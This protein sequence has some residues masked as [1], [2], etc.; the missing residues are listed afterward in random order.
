[1]TAH[2]YNTEHVHPY[3]WDQVAEAIF[4]RYPN[5]FARHVLSEDTVHRELLTG[6]TLYTRRFI[7]KTNKVPSWG[8]KYLSRLAR[9][10]PLMEESFIDTKE[11]IITMYTRSVG[12][13]SFM[14]ATE[15]VV[16]QASSE[17]PEHTVAV[18]S[19]W[20]ESSFYGLRTAIKNFG[21]ERFKKNCVKATEG[22]N[23]VLEK[24]S[25]QQASLRELGTVKL[26]EFQVKK[27]L[28]R[29]GMTERVESIKERGLHIKEEVTEKVEHMRERS[30]EMKERAKE[31]AAE[32][33]G[34]AEFTAKEVTER[35]KANATL[36]AAE[37]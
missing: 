10:V 4:Q 18:K 2:Y 8:E 23:Y 28:L 15:K 25:R 34:A 33:K 17:N 13:G 24:F 1:M 9:K 3:S 6:G 29:E 31:T 14:T 5:P 21:I 20:V 16:Y 11:K 35:V 27:D 22:F 30:R 37:D 7:T 19:A 36:H 26:A 12:F 32:V